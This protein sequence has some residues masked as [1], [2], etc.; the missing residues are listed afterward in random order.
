M[1]P[2]SGSGDNVLPPGPMVDTAGHA[3]TISNLSIMS[4]PG[5]VPEHLH[6]LSPVT[7]TINSSQEDLNANNSLVG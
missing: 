4:Q 3:S 5:S 7:N 1:L 2:L 6:S